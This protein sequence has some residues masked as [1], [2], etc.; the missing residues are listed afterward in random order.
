[1]KTC[2][3]FHDLLV[4]MPILPGASILPSQTHLLN[5][6]ERLAQHVSSTQHMRRIPSR[7]EIQATHGPQVQTIWTP[8]RP[9]LRN[10]CAC[11]CICVSE[12]RSVP[13]RRLQD[14]PLRYPFT[15]GEINGHIQQ[16]VLGNLRLD[17][18][19]PK[20]NGGKQTKCNT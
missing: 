10:V 6:H 1:M 13:N 12:L 4:V 7:R 17:K 2:Q 5:K 9:Y 11:A 20:T 15:D 8:K 19:Q 3:V 14:W 18:P 16:R